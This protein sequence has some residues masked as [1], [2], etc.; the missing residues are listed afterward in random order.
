MFLFLFQN[1]KF[2]FAA[3]SSRCSKKFFASNQPNKPMKTS[4]DSESKVVVEKDLDL[5]K[6][7]EMFQVRSLRHEPRT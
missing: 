1:S 2:V 3:K 7:T 6:V 5:L 4:F